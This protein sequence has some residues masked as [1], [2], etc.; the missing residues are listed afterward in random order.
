MF[1]DCRD[2]EEDGKNKKSDLRTRTMMNTKAFL[3][4]PRP[5]TRCGKC[6]LLRHNK[7]QKRS[8]GT[9]NKIYRILR[10]WI[11]IRGFTLRGASRM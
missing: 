2:G 3:D 8:P 1:G 11:T 10:L 7:R 6:T 4:G 5:L 9:R